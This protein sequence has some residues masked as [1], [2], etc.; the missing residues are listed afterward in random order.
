MFFTSDDAA[1]VLKTLFFFKCRLS[2]GLV[3]CFLMYTSKLVP[4]RSRLA[5]LRVPPLPSFTVD[6]LSVRASDSTLLRGNNTLMADQ[7]HQLTT[8]GTYKNEHA[9]LNF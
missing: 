5:D 3:V 6:V 8:A 4:A 1:G 9:V 7:R 2:E